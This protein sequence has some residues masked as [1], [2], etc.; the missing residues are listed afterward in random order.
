[1]DDSVE[2]Q[3]SIDSKKGSQGLAPWPPKRLT[4]HDKSCIT[5]LL[6][7]Y[8]CIALEYDVILMA[9]SKPQLDPILASV[10]KVTDQILLAVSFFCYEV[11]V[12]YKSLEYS[13]ELP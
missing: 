5:I 1:M 7:T 12:S 6:R 4:S 9:I 2:S 13:Y 3:Q 8:F 11:K 10:H